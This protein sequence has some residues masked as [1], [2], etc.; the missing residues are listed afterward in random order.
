MD[1]VTL[2]PQITC[3]NCYHCTN[4]MY[5]ICN[6]LKVIG[7]QIN[8]AAQ[9]YFAINKDMVLKIPGN[10]TFDEGAMIEPAAVAVHALGHGGDISGKK[11]LVLP[12]VENS[13][14]QYHAGLKQRDIEG[15]G[16]YL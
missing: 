8:G 10:I 9:E 16:P 7:F 3:G 1:E 11:V 14:S 13:T 2:M 15:G 6:E 4:G 12:K 5:H